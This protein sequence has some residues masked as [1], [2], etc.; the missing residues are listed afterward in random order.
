MQRR[1]FATAEE[2]WN[3]LGSTK[4]C[5][6]TGRGYA[7]VH[8]WKQVGSFPP[9]TFVVMQLALTARGCEAPAALWRMI[10]IPATLR[11]ESGV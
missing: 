5:E 11:V 10:E 2:V 1:R 6:M 4:L 7:A 9:N 8:N 3:E